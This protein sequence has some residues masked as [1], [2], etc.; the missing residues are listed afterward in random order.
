MK[1]KKTLKYLILFI[2][3]ELL[4][5]MLITYCFD[6]FYQYHTPFFGLKASLFDRDN[7]VPG[8][9]RTFSYD[10]VLLG[11]SVAE[12]FDTSYLDAAYDCN[13]LK[14][15]RASGSVADLMYYLNQAHDRQT[16]KNIFWCMDIFALSSSP[17]VTLYSS[18]T[19]RY[20][21]TS[22]VLD[23]S[24]YLF[25]KDIIFTTIPQSVAYSVLG[26][27]TGG[28]AYDWSDGKNFSADQAM[29]AYD[30]PKENLPTQ[31]V[32]EE[33]IENVA[34]NLSM[35]EDEIGSH[36]DVN[37]IVFFPPYS[38]LW[39]DC[40][41]T[42]GV[43]DEYFYVLEQAIPVLLAYDNVSMYYFQSERDIITNLDL[44]IDL[45]HYSP[46]VNQYMLECIT[47][48]QNRV[49]S[50]NMDDVLNGMHDTFDYIINE[51]IYKYYPK[52]AN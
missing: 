35:L 37:Y 48:D 34:A 11:S 18:E 43:S 5:V 50:D 41:Y 21:H 26:I 16:L 32:S 8:T 4:A 13:I 30:K 52:S 7:Q 47:S 1:E 42:N 51:G 40:G 31:P 22:S 38:M 20:L 39:W 49:T 2:A 44:Y 3:A 33:T 23:D 14:I 10:S 24:T 15:I 12:N 17:E 29:Y 9:I 45:V 36:P 19:P 46:D 27:D 6:P 28:H 25:N